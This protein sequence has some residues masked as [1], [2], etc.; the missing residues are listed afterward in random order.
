MALKQRTEQRKY[1]RIKGGKFQIGKD[2]DTTYDELEGTITSMYFKDEEFNGATNRKLILVLSDGDDHYQLGINTNSN[3]Y[4]NLVSFLRNLDLAKPVSLHPRE[5][6]LQK[7]GAEVKKNS[8]LVSQD[9]TY[10]KS[11]FTKDHP[12]GLPKWEKVTVGKKQVLDKSAYEDFLENFVTTQL[13]PNVK[14]ASTKTIVTKVPEQEDKSDPFPVTSAVED[15][16]DG[17][18]PWD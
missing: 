8:I 13:I 2:V 12:N 1:L 16:D 7:D 3:S 17:K 10:A 11:Y 4:V 9:G 14:S 5:E 18:M 6:V 15:E